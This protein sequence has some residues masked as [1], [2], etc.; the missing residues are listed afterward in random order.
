MKTPKICAVLML[1][2]PAATSARSVVV[3]VTKDAIAT[4]A[5]QRL[6]SATDPDT[7]ALEWLNME[8][9]ENREQ[10]NEDR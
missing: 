8:R 4:P 10:D 2:E 6:R 9:T 1:V 3:G 5:F 7:T